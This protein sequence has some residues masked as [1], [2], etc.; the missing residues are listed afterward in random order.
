MQR[1][2]EGLKFETSWSVS[3]GGQSHRDAALWPVGSAWLG[4]GES[5]FELKSEAASDFQDD[6]ST[7]KERELI[8]EALSSAGAEGEESP[9]G[10]GSFKVA[11]PSLWSK[12][13]G[14]FEVARISMS[15]IL[16]Y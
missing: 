3:A 16:A 5:G 4:F 10:K 13:I 15:Y 14:I 9:F 7:F 2:I 12:F 6:Y 11:A 1:E 8:T